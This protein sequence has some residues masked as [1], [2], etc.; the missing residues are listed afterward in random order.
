MMT[1]K[2]M[3]II[4]AGEVGSRAA[5]ELREKG[6]TGKVTLIGT[7][8]WDPYYRP[9]LSKDFLTAEEETQPMYTFDKGI[10]EENDITLLSGA[11]VTKINR[12]DR[13]VT[14]ADGQRI[15]F[16]RLLLATGATSRKLPV[17]GSGASNVLYLRSYA[18]ARKIR[19]QLQADK[20]V[21]VIGGGFIGLEVAASAKKRGCSVTLIEIG[22]RILTRGVPEEIAHIMEAKHR[23]EGVN[24]KIGAGISSIDTTN[25]INVI[26]LTDGTSVRCDTIIAGIGAIPETS[27]AAECGLEIE[28]GVRVNAFLE[29]NDPN[30]F[31]AGDCCSFPHGLFSEKRIRLESWRNAQDQG[32]HVAENMLGAAKPFIVVPWFWSDQYDQTLQVTGL[33]D[34]GEETVIRDLG[35]TGKLFFHLSN[36]G[37]LVGASGIGSAKIGRD[38]RLAE[39]LIQKQVKPDPVTLGN[40]EVK[41]KEMLKVLQ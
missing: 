2:G 36:N 8:E 29:T 4:G 9:H 23:T 12:D 7:E 5:V 33:I 18:D 11:V 24:F 22:P 20:H 31:A 39:M 37:Y 21:V 13:Y 1:E 19:S 26:E 32:L 41:L 38:I 17:E 25:G 28:N 10:L 30:I 6:W 15:H 16:E 14:L 34:S 40:Q 3:V 27:L 35:E